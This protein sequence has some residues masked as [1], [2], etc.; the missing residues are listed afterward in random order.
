MYLYLV[1]LDSILRAGQDPR[2][3][4]DLFFE[5]SKGQ[6]FYGMPGCI[7]LN[8][9]FNYTSYPDDMM[10]KRSHYSF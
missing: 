10:Y 2:R 9:V 5:K 1:V 8:Y 6:I 3:G 4:G 7:K